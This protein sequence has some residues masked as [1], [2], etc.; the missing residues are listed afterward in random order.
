MTF[1]DE[2]RGIATGSHGRVLMTDDGGRTWINWQAPISEFL[3]G[4]VF[5]PSGRAFVTGYRLTIFEMVPG[6][7]R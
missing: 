1:A 3:D 5:S 2:R 4:A 7:P 6:G